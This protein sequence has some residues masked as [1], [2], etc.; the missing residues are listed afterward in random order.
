MKMQEMMS[1]IKLSDEVQDIV[2][3]NALVEEE[4]QKDKELFYCD[5][6]NFFEKWDNKEKRF[7][8][9]LP[10]YIRLAC[11]VYEKYQE[12]GISD[13]IFADTFYDIT[14][15]NEDSDILFKIVV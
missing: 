3:Q 11:E 10:F 15:W 5:I 7:Q 2:L 6:K 13:Q 1:R 14:L 8:W 12:K 9:I 4:Y